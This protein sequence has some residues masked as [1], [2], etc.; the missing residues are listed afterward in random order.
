[1]TTGNLCGFTGARYR[2]AAPFDFPL[3]ERCPFYTPGKGKA[4]AH[5]MLRGSGAECQ[6]DAAR[7][8]ARRWGQ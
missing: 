5:R 7:K 1:M 2:C 4:C 6:S 8:T 3:Q